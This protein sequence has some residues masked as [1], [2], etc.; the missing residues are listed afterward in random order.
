MGYRIKRWCH[1][2]LSLGILNVANHLAQLLA[3]SR[4]VVPSLLMQL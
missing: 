4:R 3:R 2:L 1:V